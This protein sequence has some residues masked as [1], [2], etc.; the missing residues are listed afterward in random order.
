MKVDVENVGICTNTK[1]N[2]SV[3]KN[4][5]IVDLTKINWYEEFQFFRRI[6]GT[7]VNCI[8]K[9]FHKE[10]R[11]IPVAIKYK[12]SV[13]V[14]FFNTKHDPLEIYNNRDS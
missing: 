14:L 12:T 3:I 8:M 5:P 2:P 1:E 13:D 11:W 7:I 6:T 10:I 4:K 9:A